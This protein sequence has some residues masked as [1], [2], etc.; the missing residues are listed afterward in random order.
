MALPVPVVGALQ[1][2]WAFVKRFYRE[3]AI[4]LLLLTAW[5]FQ[6]R[7][8]HWHDQTQVC[9][10]GREADR[11]A[12]EKAAADAK[13]KN[14]ADVRAIEQQWQ[15]KVTE[16]EENYN[17]QLTA[18]RADVAAYAARMRQ[19]IA[20]NKGATSGPGVSYPAGT[21]GA[22]SGAGGATLIP[23]PEGDLYICAANTVK[24]EQW[25][26]FYGNLR[27]SW[28]PDRKPPE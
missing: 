4:V 13:A 2:A 23:V 27:T 16:T 9:Q 19:A 3:I 25:Q 7:A 11:K 28:P 18:A 20:A 21:P 26:S 17:A 15:Q 8:T 22:T 12:Y 10:S 1:T 6:S 24:A 14:L 5:H